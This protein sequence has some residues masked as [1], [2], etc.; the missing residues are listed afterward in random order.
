MLR[1][2][3]IFAIFVCIFAFP[4]PSENEEEKIIFPQEDLIETT[5]ASLEIESATD[6][7]GTEVES[8]FLGFGL[9]LGYALGQRV[10]GHQPY[11]HSTYYDRGMAYK[12]L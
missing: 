1:L 3:V 12:F 5:A 7:N 9:G 2:V 8:R 10:F 11:H 6:Q 4:T